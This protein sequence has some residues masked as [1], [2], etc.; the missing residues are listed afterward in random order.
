MSV[1]EA[2]RPVE[3]RNS[4]R[5]LAPAATPG[6]LR[7][8]SPGTTPGPGSTLMSKASPTDPPSPSLAV[9]LTDT[10]PASAACGVPA[11]VRVLSAKDSQAGSAAPSACVAV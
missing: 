4:S 5:N 2:S 11:K 8:Q 7:L 10:V 9:T 6:G 3:E 1:D